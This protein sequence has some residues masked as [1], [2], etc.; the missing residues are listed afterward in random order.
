MPL[1]ANGLPVDTSPDRFGEFEPAN[2][3]LGHAVG[4]RERM[5]DRGHL[6]FRGLLPADTVLLRMSTSVAPVPKFT[7]T[8][9][10]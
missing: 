4:L 5:A 1:T 6:F 10:Y 2:D 9:R 8:G 3:L 7:R